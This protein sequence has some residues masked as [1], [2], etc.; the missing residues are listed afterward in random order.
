MQAEDRRY[1]EKTEEHKQKKPKIEAKVG[2]G[3][4]GGGGVCGLLR[5]VVVCRVGTSGQEKVSVS[6]STRVRMGPAYAQPQ[7]STY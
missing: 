5:V 2:G 4:G 7:L 3:G 1:W 6:V